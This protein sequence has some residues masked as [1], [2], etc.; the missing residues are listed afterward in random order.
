MNISQLARIRAL[1]PSLRRVGDGRYSLFWRIRNLVQLERRSVAAHLVPVAKGKRAYGDDGTSG[2]NWVL[3]RN[4]HPR[5][6]SEWLE[7]N[8]WDSREIHSAYDCTGQYFARNPSIRASGNRVL[9][10]Q[11]WGYDI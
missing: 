4:T 11:S 7:M 6:V 9:V 8:G 3:F 2:L 1:V 5:I 10:T